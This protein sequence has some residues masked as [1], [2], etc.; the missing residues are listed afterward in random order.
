VNRFVEYR[1]LRIEDGFY[2]SKGSSM[3]FEFRFM[4]QIVGYSV[5]FSLNTYRLASMESVLTFW[6]S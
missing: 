2:R 4:G 6:K 1:K 3:V 5:T